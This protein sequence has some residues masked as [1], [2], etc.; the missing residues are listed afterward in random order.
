M[1]A[2]AVL[3]G[4][5]L[6]LSGL[7][8]ELR[9]NVNDEILDQDGEPC[10]VRSVD[11]EDPEK[12]YEL[13]Y[14]NGES[15]WAAESALSP[16]LVKAEA[17]NTE[18]EPNLSESIP[19]GADAAAD[20]A[21]VGGEK[22]ADDKSLL[23]IS[24]APDQSL[25][26]S[27]SIENSIS[28]ADEVADSNSPPAPASTKLDAAAHPDKLQLPRDERLGMA[29]TGDA[30]AD[31][32][33]VAADHS[34]SPVSQT[35][36]SKG[37]A[38]AS[39]AHGSASLVFRPASS[40][41]LTDWSVP[42]LATGCAVCYALIRTF[43][44]A[45]SSMAAATKRV[46]TREVA[47]NGSGSNGTGKTV[48]FFSSSGSSSGD[49]Q[50]AG[51]RNGDG[52]DLSATAMQQAT[53]QVTYLTDL[54]AELTRAL[55][56]LQRQ[57]SVHTATV[58]GQAAEIMQFKRTRGEG[59]LEMADLR[60]KLHERTTSARAVC[61]SEL[62]RFSSEMVAQLDTAEE[63]VRHLSKA[64]EHLE[65]MAATVRG[66]AAEIALFKNRLLKESADSKHEI[67]E[68]QR[69][70]AE[71]DDELR[72]LEQEQYNMSSAERSNKFIASMQ[73]ELAMWKEKAESFQAKAEGCRPEA[74]AAKAETRGLHAQIESLKKTNEAL[75]R[76]CAV[77]SNFQAELDRLRQELLCMSSE[78][79][80]IKS[81]ANA[82]QAAVLRQSDAPLAT[83]GGDSFDQRVEE[84]LSKSLNLLKAKQAHISSAEKAS[85]GTE[86]DLDNLERQDAQPCSPEAMLLTDLI[87]MAPL[88][89]T[90]AKKE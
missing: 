58:V 32:V 45:G 18:L 15:Y 27:S 81:K 48:R 39:Q 8:T 69:R 74:D 36:I 5:A 56:S 41:W 85:R 55:A 10:R 66:Q 21:V 16:R 64:L 76:Q 59:Q 63:E 2:I 68:L 42:L 52:L 25:S 20:A 84:S 83:N 11:P 3:V 46:D 57:A 12:P 26:A 37:P 89:V 54:D 49:R 90:P 80:L 40:T 73:R 22:H 28:T 9:F 70:L 23:A 4:F 29:S 78:M 47:R 88:P 7:G 31:G 86:K 50:V 34:D 35:A 60:S 75:Q 19:S 72:R 17:N 51:S 71:R 38:A 79:G 67:S 87:P 53:Q 1:R 24:V 65:R 14:T 43:G 82:K 33:A 77:S 62:I 13:L 6:A 30:A 44:L 61:E